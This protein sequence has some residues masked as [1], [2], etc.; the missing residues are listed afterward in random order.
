M[1]P[2]RTASVALGGLALLAPIIC[3]PLLLHPRVG[4]GAGVAALVTLL[5]WAS[6]G[7]ALGLAHAGDLAPLL[8][9]S[10]TSGVSL[11][12]FVAVTAATVFAVVR[13]PE[14]LPGRMVFYLPVLLSLTLL[15]VMLAR[16]PDSPAESY[17]SHKLKA[18]VFL[19][20]SLLVAGLVVGTRRRD[21]SRSL[22]I[23]L[24]VAFI[25]G[26]ALAHEILTGVQPLFEG[27]YAISNA[28]YDPIVLGRI[29]ASGL[30]IAVYLLLAP[31]SR[32]RIAAALAVPLMTISLLASGG[33]G[34]LVGVI[35]GLVIL[36][37]V[38][39]VFRVR[40][41]TIAGALAA[42]LVVALIVVPGI[43]SQRATSLFFGGSEG[44]SSGG[45]S[46]LW[47]QALETFVNHP[48]GGIGTGGFASF[49]PLDRYPHNLF[50]ETAS[51][52]GVLGLIPL[53]GALGIGAG[54]IAKAIGYSKGADRGMLTLV[55]AL[56]ASAFVNA[57]FSTDISSNYDVWL[58][59]GLG[60]GLVSR[61][62]RQSSRSS[63]SE[64]AAT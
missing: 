58:F 30:L 53:V 6:P 33:R 41:S 57:M 48:L 10:A 21:V 29:S 34:A 15:L 8:G 1:I 36:L 9:G 46:G 14:R 32:F 45:R 23:M 20:L 51:E 44:R 13:R 63:I 42:S 11:E 26:L 27:R 37:G 5:F 49:N 38:P 62:D 3:L 52:L 31:G 61:L 43:A 17:G 12:L 39:S 22:G 47:A 35:A 4:L 7:N 60:V 2:R 64:A 25:A 56:F 50:L 55:A 16:L 18:F 40:R 54:M 24:V 28:Q 59:L 19:N